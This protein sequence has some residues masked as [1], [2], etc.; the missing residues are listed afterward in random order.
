MVY[1]CSHRW[2]HNWNS[3]DMRN[4]LPQRRLSIS[5]EFKHKGDNGQMFSYRATVGYYDNGQMGELFLNSSKRL[6]TALDANARDAAIFVSI[7]LQYGAP[8]EILRG[9]Q[10]RN[11]E[12]Y[13]SSPVGMALD[14]I[15]RREL[16]NFF[17]SPKTSGES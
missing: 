15:I 10:A 1:H 2:R 7:A 4:K 16:D 17:E 12:G 9:A 5:F 11:I 6:G 14:E 3:N 13:P 8:L